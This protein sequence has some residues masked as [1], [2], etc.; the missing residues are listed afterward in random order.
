MS[1]IEPT[2]PAP[3]IV[4][5][6]SV[7]SPTTINAE[8]ATIK[9]DQTRRIH[10]GTGSGWSQSLR[11][12][13]TCVKKRAGRPAAMQPS[14]ITGCLLPQRKRKRPAGPSLQRLAAD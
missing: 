7:S 4:S 9:S 8:T 3:I 11:R 6:S 12:R 5:R 10:S 1:T 2:C 13:S 14:A